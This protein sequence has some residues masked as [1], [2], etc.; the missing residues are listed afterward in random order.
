M[1]PT[2]QLQWQRHRHRQRQQ[3]Q[4][5][6]TA[7]SQPTVGGQQA[8]HIHGSRIWGGWVWLV[9]AWSL[10][11]RT[12]C[13]VGPPKSRQRQRQASG[14]GEL[15][16]FF[17]TLAWTVWRMI[18]SCGSF[19]VRTAEQG[20]ICWEASENGRAAAAA[21]GAPAPSACARAHRGTAHPAAPCTHPFSVPRR[22]LVVGRPWLKAP[23]LWCRAMGSEDLA[24]GGAKCKGMAVIARGSAIVSSSLGRAGPGAASCRRLQSFR[25]LNPLHKL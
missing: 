24:F 10:W 17:L 2:Q 23:A 11:D 7:Q 13:G 25:R 22:G 6:C 12:G 14:G 15:N 9:Q 1:Q 5:H 3:Q 19:G 4:A 18:S 20:E 8:W 16:V 21:A